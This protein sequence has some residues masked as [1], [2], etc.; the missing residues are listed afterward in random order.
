MQTDP[1]IDPVAPPNQPLEESNGEQRPL[2]D[3]PPDTDPL[4][5]GSSPED[6]EALERAPRRP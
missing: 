3:T 5:P 1:T 6:E 2:P 4:A